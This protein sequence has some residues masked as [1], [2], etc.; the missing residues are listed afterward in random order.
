MSSA[1]EREHDNDLVDEAVD[2][3][4]PASDPPSWTLGPATTAAPDSALRSFARTNAAGVLVPTVAIALGLGAGLVLG[5]RRAPWARLAAGF[6]TGALLFGLLNA[7][8]RRA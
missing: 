3:S 6:G 1:K 2:E 4:F 8:R 5:G 7:A